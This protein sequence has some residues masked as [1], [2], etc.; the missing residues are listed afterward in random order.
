MVAPSG[1]SGVHWL[2]KAGQSVG[3]FRPCKIS[4]RRI[5]RQSLGPHRESAFRIELRVLFGD[6]DSQ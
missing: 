3:F 5:H 1:Y 6:A 2:P 4:P